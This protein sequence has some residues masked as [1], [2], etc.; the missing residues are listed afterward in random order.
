MQPLRC[1]A[2]TQEQQKLMSTDA[3]GVMNKKERTG[4][5]GYL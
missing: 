5:R 3:C 1:G 2:C 4:H